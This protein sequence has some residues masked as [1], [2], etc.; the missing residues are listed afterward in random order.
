M[1]KNWTINVGLEMVMLLL[2]LLLLGVFVAPAVA[3][4]CTQV[5]P[6]DI[7]DR[8]TGRSIV[9]LTAVALA[10]KSGEVRLPIVGLDRTRT[11]RLI[12]L[13]DE[14]GSMSESASSLF[15]YQGEALRLIKQ[16]LRDLMAELPPGVSVEYGLFNET[17]VFS[18]GFISD[19][20]ELRKSVDEVTAR[21]GK[22][23]YGKTALYDSVYEA[24]TRFQTPQPGDSILLLT[25]GGDNRSKLPPKK[26][27]RELRVARVRLLTMFKVGSVLEEEGPN[28]VQ[29]FS[30]S[31]GGAFLA[32]D[33]AST[34]WTDK[35]AVA[36]NAQ[37]LRNFWNDKVLAGYVVHVQVPATFKNETKWKLLVNREADLRLKHAVVTYPDRLSP[38]PVT[39]ATVH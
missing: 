23:G 18:E 16:T 14:S 36:K 21:F 31:T 35:K 3:R 28:W 19:P 1:W 20:K 12:V 25:D 5:V 32:I 11:G 30:A 4:D 8:D 10:A 6:I 34:S 22:K 17:W 29:E 27:E 26:L 37:V 33:S 13:I 2:A 15:S 9:P 39:T 7:F 24:L 38:C